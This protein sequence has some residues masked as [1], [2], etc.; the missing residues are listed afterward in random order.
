MAVNCP[1]AAVRGRVGRRGGGR[2]RGWAGEVGLPSAVRRLPLQRRRCRPGGLPGQRLSESKKRYN[3]EL[4]SSEF[5]HGCDVPS[6]ADPGS[7]IQ[8]Q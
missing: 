4:Q 1:T 7:G 3:R 2:G 8:K 5:T 6:V